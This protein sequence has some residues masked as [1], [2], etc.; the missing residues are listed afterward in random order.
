M[1]EQVRDVQAKLEEARSDAVRW[2]TRCRLAEEQASALRVE[3]TSLQ[4]D[5]AKKQEEIRSLWDTRD[6]LVASVEDL[7]ARLV[8]S[9]AALQ[10][11]QTRAQERVTRLEAALQARRRA[12]LMWKLRFEEMEKTVEAAHRVLAGLKQV[13]AVGRWVSHL[14]ALIERSQSKGR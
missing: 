1:H 10:A 5:L 4:D 6:R 3:M 13:P 8:D 12:S 7:K 2:R 11:A 14:D 9:D